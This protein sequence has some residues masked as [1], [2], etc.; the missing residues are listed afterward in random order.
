MAKLHLAAGSWPTL[1]L[2][3]G[4]II[5]FMLREL[6][7]FSAGSRWLRLIECILL[8]AIMSCLG[9]VLSYVA[10]LHSTG[11]TDATLS[12]MDVAIGFDWRRADQFVLRHPA[13]HDLLAN[14]YLTCFWFP[15]VIWG[16]LSWIDDGARLYRF[17]LAFGIALA[18]T[19]MIF[20]FFPARA[21][22]DYYGGGAGLPANARQYGAAI[23]GLRD[24]SL[25]TI[26]LA[27]LQGIITF[28]SFHAAMAVLFVWA[29]WPAKWLRAASL[30]INGLMWVAAVPIG[31]HYAVDLIGG[32]LVA[33]AAIF[34]TR[35]WRADVRSKLASAPHRARIAFAANDHVLAD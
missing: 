7:S 15:F 30:A 34:L 10:M 29:V 9:A 26:D 13:F 25:T 33:W 20:F 22:F 31:G 4:G 1:R 17:L 18:A 14:A 8:F 16:V 11:F 35:P 27:H 2:F 24:G 32:S 19:D 5:F 21:A 28:P 12:H 3:T 23:A 6:S